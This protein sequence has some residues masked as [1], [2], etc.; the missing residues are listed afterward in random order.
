MGPA[1]CP[2]P[3]TRGG[4]GVRSGGTATTATWLFGWP[5]QPMI[6]TPPGIVIV[7][8][9]SSGSVTTRACPGGIGMSFAAGS[10]RS[11]GT[12]PRALTTPAWMSTV[13]G[14]VG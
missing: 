11:F 13:T 7:K 8:P 5:S 9:G 1:R 12:K 4:S 6:C 14:T 3:T 10:A 2:G